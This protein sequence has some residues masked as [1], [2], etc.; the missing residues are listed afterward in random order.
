MRVDAQLTNFTTRVSI[1]SNG[2]EGNG[3]SLHPSISADGRYVAF[4]SDADNL[5]SNDTNNAMDVFLHDCITSQT[6][7][8]SIASNGTEGNLQATQNKKLLEN[9][10][11]TTSGPV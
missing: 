11:S 8:V 7:R 1:A 10:L 3:I 2:T 9:S 5:V 4:S 6:A